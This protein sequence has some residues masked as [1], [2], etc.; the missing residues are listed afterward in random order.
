VLV[1]IGAVIAGTV[2]SFIENALGGLSYGKVLANVASILILL[3]FVKSALD[4]VGIATTV[5]GPLLYTDPRHRRRRGHHRRRRWAHQAHAGPLGEHAQQGR[6]RERQRQGAGPGSS[7][8]SAPPAT[9]T[10]TSP[11]TRAP[12]PA[13]PSRRPPTPRPQTYGTSTR[14]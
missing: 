4:Q 7:R 3:G 11:P 5:T 12:R 14:R 8:R 1:V 9:P 13:A 6:D 10:R 2:K